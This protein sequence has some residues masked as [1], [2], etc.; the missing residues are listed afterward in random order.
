MSDHGP[1][2]D[3][4]NGYAELCPQTSATSFAGKRSGA[5]GMVNAFA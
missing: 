1:H 5:V 2:S 3:F 4:E